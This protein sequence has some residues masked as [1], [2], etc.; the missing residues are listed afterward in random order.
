VHPQRPLTARGR[1]ETEAVAR[2]AAERVDGVDVIWHSTKT[3]ARETAEILA[4]RLSPSGG[5]IEREGLT[6]NDPVGPVA[7]EIES[8]Q[9]DLILVSHIPFVHR[10]SGRLL[11]GEE[12]AEPVCFNTA[13]FACLEADD[14]LH[15]KL[16]WMLDPSEL[17]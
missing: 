7:V 12:E 14:A 10:M 5:L 15:W 11:I 1:E 9:G 6:P 13:G 16:A 4:K 8:L 2:A 3:R 17:M